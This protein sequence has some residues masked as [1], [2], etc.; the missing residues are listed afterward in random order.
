MAD[1]F[2]KIRKMVREDLKIDNKLIKD[3]EIKAIVDDI[4]ALRDQTNNNVDRLKSFEKRFQEKLQA[5]R[6]LSLRDQMIKAQNELKK[7]RINARINDES[8]GGDKGA[9][10][11]AELEG[12]GY[13]ILIQRGSMQEAQ[14]SRAIMTGNL[15]L[16]LEKEALFDLLKDRSIEKE[17][18]VAIYDSENGKPINANSL[19]GKASKYF[20]AAANSIRQG[21]EDAGHSI[22]KIPGWIMRQSHD[23]EKIA[24][25][26][27]GWITDQLKLLDHEKTFDPG[28]TLREKV[29]YLE[30]TGQQIIDGKWGQLKTPA[31][32]AEDKLTSLSNMGIVGKAARSERS[33]H[34]KDGENFYEY[35]SK[36]GKDSLLDSTFRTIDREARNIALIKKFGTAPENTIDSLIKAHDLNSNK[37]AIMDAY[38]AVRGFNNTEFPNE[39]VA[40]TGVIA[41]AMQSTSKLTFTAIRAVNDV[42]TAAALIQSATGKNMI[43]VY[44]DMIP[45]FLDQAVVKTG[46]DRKEIANQVGIFLSDHLHEQFR[47]GTGDELPNAAGR[48]FG[49]VLKAQD[50]YF[51]YTGIHLQET[52]ARTTVAKTLSRIFAD[53]SHLDFGKLD[54]QLQTTFKRF[55]LGEQEWELMRSVKDE[56]HDG[57]K[58]ITMEG[59]DGVDSNRIDEILGMRRNVRQTESQ[60]K[61]DVKNKLASLYQNYGDLTVLGT[62]ARYQRIWTAGH[63]AGTLAGESARLALQFKGAAMTQADAL[64]RI[65]GASGKLEASSVFKNVIPYLAFA[66]A[67]A[68]GID[69]FINV[70]KNKPFDDP[71]S[72]DTWT[73]SFNRAGAGG[74]YQDLITGGVASPMDVRAHS[75][76]GKILSNVFGPTASNVADIGGA[77]ISGQGTDALN[78]AAS[79]LPFANL[80]RNDQNVYDVLLLNH[81]NEFLNPGFNARRAAKRQKMINR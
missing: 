38:Y 57:T 73:H 41:R 31:E 65:A 11:K 80:K 21:Y 52:T 4:T 58:G 27:P 81:I 2:D 43:G 56:F 64:L 67:S 74:I 48:F 29:S 8:L 20:V 24:K 7:T 54:P 14:R 79:N 3:D 26:L 12:G 72:V 37:K 9:R 34:Y 39:L 50:L 49:G 35:N 60:F 76:G 36:W 55:G 75:Y 71:T 61:N 23:P 18:M 44:A 51:K 32:G 47:H 5:Q 10:L 70:V 28:M 19:G 53:D 40:K 63:P 25:D 77:V 78:K 15:Q 46:M 66:T 1:C 42:N 59:I 6:E 17:T 22:G 30:S 68:Y 69:Q 13:N 16:G 62:Q 33:F 45:E